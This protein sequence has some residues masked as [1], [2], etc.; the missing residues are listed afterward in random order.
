MDSQAGLPAFKYHPN[1]LGTGSV[2]PEPETTCLACEQI[3]G[4]IYTGPVYAEGNIDLDEQLC[5]WCIAD[6]TAASK[7]DTSFNDAGTMEDV[8]EEVMDEIEQRTPGFISWQESQWLTCCDDAAAFLGLAGAKELR[9]DFPK[10]LPAV[11]EYLREE[12]DL[13]GEELKEFLESLDKDDQ[14]TAYVFQ[15]LHCHNF[16]AYVDET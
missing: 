5:P 10:A 13:S 7:F 1:P 8:S 15:C 2:Q 16:L 9:R 14:P 3:R 4:Y 11:K 12:F 6:G